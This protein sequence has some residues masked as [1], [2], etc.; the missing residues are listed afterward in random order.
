MTLQDGVH[1]DRDSV[2][3]GRL[4]C[5]VCKVSTSFFISYL[6]S[7]LLGGN[8]SWWNI[9]VFIASFIWSPQRGLEKINLSS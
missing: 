1:G 7:A 6:Y 3:E 4:C 9:L 5:L 2:V 8:S